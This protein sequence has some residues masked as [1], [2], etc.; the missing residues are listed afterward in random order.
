M[1]LFSLSLKTQ[2]PFYFQKTFRRDI[3]LFKKS[4]VNRGVTVDIIMLVGKDDD[5]I[6]YNYGVC[7]E[8][9]F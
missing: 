4:E 3:G 7:I 1:L 2:R 6:Q 5:A 9:I 8:I